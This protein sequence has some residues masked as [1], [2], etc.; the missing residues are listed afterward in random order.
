MPVLDG[1]AATRRLLALDPA[2]RVIVVSG[3]TDRLAREAALEAGATAYLTKSEA[4]DALADDDRGGLRPKLGSAQEICRTRAACGAGGRAPGGEV[5]LA[6][7]SPLG[8]GL[9]GEG[10]FRPRRGRQGEGRPGHWFARHAVDR[11][12]RERERERRERDRVAVDVER[13]DRLLFANV[14]QARW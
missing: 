10:S 2:P 14:S 7:W 3:H 5:A 9:W 12:R 6:A 8:E 1:P 13:V 11:L 4:F